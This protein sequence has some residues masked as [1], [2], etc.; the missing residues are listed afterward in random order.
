[1][2][3]QFKVDV[4]L[5]V[6]ISANCRLLLY[7]YQKTRSNFDKYAIVYEKHDKKIISVKCE[8]I[9]NDI[10]LFVYNLN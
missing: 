1:M 3:R 2:S 8:L 10:Q 9:I 4:P 5:S 7:I 6:S